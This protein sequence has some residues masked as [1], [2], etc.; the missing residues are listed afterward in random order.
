MSRCEIIPNLP[1]TWSRLPF[2]NACITFEVSPGIDPCPTV[3][4]PQTLAL[5]ES[6][7]L[8]LWTYLLPT[9][10]YV[11][12]FQRH[13]ELLMVDASRSCFA[14]LQTGSCGDLRHHPHDHTFN[15][16]PFSHHADD[17]WPTLMIFSLLNSV[18]E[19]LI[20]CESGGTL[21]NTALMV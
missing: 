2:R 21:A 19:V 6:T 15:Y 20:C 7:Q 5:G 13:K 14:R 1:R 17:Q 3:T 11:D 9:V 18:E 10:Q 4:R 8:S 12:S 16:S